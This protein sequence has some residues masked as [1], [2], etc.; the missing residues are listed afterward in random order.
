[1]YSAVVLKTSNALYVTLH[2]ATKTFPGHDRTNTETVVVTADTV[3]AVADVLD[4]D[5]VVMV[6]TLAWKLLQLS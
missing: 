6:V 4:A 5:A 1:M 2:L 3:V